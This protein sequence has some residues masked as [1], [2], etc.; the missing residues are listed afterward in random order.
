MTPRQET[1][2]KWGLYA[3][4]TLLCCAVQGAVL[5]YVSVLGVFPF[6]YPILA[7][8]LATLEGPFPGAVYALALGLVCDLTIS[9][10]SPAFTRWS[11][12]WRDC[13][14]AGLPAGCSP[15]AFSARWP[16]RPP[17]SC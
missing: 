6:L 17:R 11:F 7:A 3:L 4:V 12:R 5:Q 10:P 1:V 14:R 13:W 15:P 9:P 2:Y 16:P 8:V